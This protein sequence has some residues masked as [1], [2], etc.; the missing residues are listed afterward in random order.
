MK[1]HPFMTKANAFPYLSTY[2]LEAGSSIFILCYIP[3]LCPL[4]GKRRA[5][6]LLVLQANTDQLDNAFDAGRPRRGFKYL[7]Y[8]S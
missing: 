2:V 3:F 1:K 5:N 4:E 6:K 7:R 8:Y